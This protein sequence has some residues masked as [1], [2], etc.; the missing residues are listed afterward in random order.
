[1]LVTT[2]KSIQRDAENEPHEF[3]SPIGRTIWTLLQSGLYDA[4]R[5]NVIVVVT[6]ALTTYE[7]D[8]EDL[9]D[10]EERHEAW[11][12]DAAKKKRFIYDICDRA[13]PGCEPWPVVF[14][15]NGS[16][17]KGLAE[18]KTLPNGEQSHL[19]LFDA[20]RSIFNQ[21]PNEA[22]VQALHAVTLLA[23][24]AK[25]AHAEKETVVSLT[26]NEVI[27]NED[28]QQVWYSPER[29]HAL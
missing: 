26:S 15:E 23:K 5:P 9:E 28:V 20:M 27:T 4:Y 25:D 14:V 29:S 22:D 13:L 10:E 6:C 21:D 24:G 8:Y 3:Q 11:R 16:G 19:N 12:R 7:S 17:R 2:W 18:F 1:M